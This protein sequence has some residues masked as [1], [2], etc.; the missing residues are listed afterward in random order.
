MIISCRNSGSKN[1]GLKLE[2]CR[3][4]LEIINMDLSECEAN[5]SS[6]R[7]KDRIVKQELHGDT[8]FLSMHFTENCCIQ[9]FPCISLNNKTLKIILDNRSEGQSYCDCMCCFDISLTIKGIPNLDF[10]TALENR[11][12]SYSTEMYNTYNVTFKL[13]GHDTINMTNKYGFKV[14]IWRE[15]YKSGQIKSE[16]NYEQDFNVIGD[17]IVW[18]KYFSPD[19]L[20]VKE[21]NFDTIRKNKSNK[22]R[23]LK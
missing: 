8:L 10:K 21:N 2:K 12:I 16:I 9:L 5:I 19:G 15:Y 3:N 14:G 6:Y 1:E 20:L 17:K 23:Y 11:L 22:N 7:L 4:S 18:S 13:D